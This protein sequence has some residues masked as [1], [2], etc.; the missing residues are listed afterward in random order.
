MNILVVEDE[1]LMADF[2]KR[3]LT[4][5]GH[6]ITVVHDGHEGQAYAM[7]G[8][9]DIILLD[10]MLP[11][12]SG[13]EVCES[14]RGAGVATPILMLTALDSVPDRVRGL[15]QGADDYLVKP[16]AF[17]ELIARIDAVVRRRTRNRQEGNENGGRKLVHGDIVFDRDTLQISRAGHPLSLTAK[18][19]GILELLLDRP[20]NVVS[21]ERILNSV[22]GIHADP[23]TNI[24]EVYIGRLRRKLQEHGPPAIETVRSFGY[25][26]I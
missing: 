16:Y 15:K 8:N 10:I 19:I 13:L 6:V 23:L 1:P 17:D 21:R 14:L 3:G 11:G 4:A 7:A 26:L 22:W 24:V 25:R 2:I 18:E 5:E 20:G 9:Y 12:Q